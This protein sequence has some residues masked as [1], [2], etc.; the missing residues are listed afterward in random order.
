MS[1]ARG[2][3]TVRRSL[4]QP[5]RETREKLPAPGCSGCVLLSYK[6]AKGFAPTL[7]A[8]LALSGIFNIV[9]C[10][11]RYL[12]F[13]GEE[14]RGFATGRVAVI[15]SFHRARIAKESLRRISIDNVT[16]WLEDYTYYPLNSRTVS[17][18]KKK[19]VRPFL[20]SSRFF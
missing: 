5:R 19:R 13:E 20:E 3:V 12:T 17:A 1:S 15:E 11:F 7:L 14:A 16:K 18:A 2:E 9:P 4:T 10:F 8:G 6:F